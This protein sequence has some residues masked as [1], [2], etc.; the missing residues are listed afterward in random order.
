[1]LTVGQLARLSGLTPKALRHYHD[2]GVLCPVSVD[3]DNGYRLYGRGQVQT[4]LHIR[5]LRDLDVPLADV[6]VIV[7]ATDPEAASA[8]LRVHRDRVGAR[9]ASLQTSYYLLGKMIE[10][11]EPIDIMYSRPTAVSLE[12]DRQRTLA[13]ELFNY[14][15]T[16][17]ETEDRSDRQ[18]ELMVAAAYASRFFWEE[19]GEPFRLARGEWQISRACAIAGRADAALGHAQIC[20]ALCETHQL[21]PF[22]VGYAHEALAR[23]H[24]TAGDH[25]AADEHVRA[26]RAIAP[27]ITDPDE[28]DLLSSDLDALA[29]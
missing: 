26:A 20:L 8:R 17:M 12:R 11:K 13:A 28:R 27:Q 9:L 10:E 14:V 18:T 4:A 22:D 6:G 3:A 16:L 7:H 19:T 2:V 21:E 25:D 1:M 29:I 24:Q 5:V 15:W 23:A